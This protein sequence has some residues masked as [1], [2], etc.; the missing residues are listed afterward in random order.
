MLTWWRPEVDNPIL[1]VIGDLKQRSIHALNEAPWNPQDHTPEH[2]ERLKVS[3]LRFG[4]L[5]PLVVRATDGLV[6]G[7]HGRLRAA[8]SLWEEGY[9]FSG[10]DGDRLPCMEGVWTDDQA[11]WLNLAL[12][13]IQQGL[14]PERVRG[15]LRKLSDTWTVGDLTVAGFTA[16]RVDSILRGSTRT[17]RARPKVR[18]SHRTR[19]RKVTLDVA[20]DTYTTLA[21]VRDRFGSDDEFLTTALAR[22]EGDNHV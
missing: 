2:V 14:D 19:I 6:I 11:K 17:R 12:N 4:F 13:H 1:P 9:G 7:G 8:L 21:G 5:A 10:A 22:L 15:I 20:A 16:K 3:I 18:R